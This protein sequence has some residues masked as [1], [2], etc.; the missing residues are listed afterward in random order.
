MA[1]IRAGWEDGGRVFCNVPHGQQVED[2]VV[3]IVLECRGWRQNN[4][5]VASGLVEVEINRDHE[6][7][8]VES[9][10]ELHS[11]GSRQHRVPGHRHQTADP[12]RTL[13][14]NFLGEGGYRQLAAKLGKPAHPAFSPP[15][16]AAAGAGQQIHRRFGEHCSTG[17]VEISGDNV[18]H[19]DEPLAETTKSLGGHTHSAVAHGRRSRRKVARYATNLVACD[20]RGSSDAFGRK[21]PSQPPNG[22]QR[23][24]DLG[25]A[26]GRLE[27]LSEDHMQE[28]HQQQ[29]VASRTDEVVAIGDSCRL[30]A[31]RVDHHQPAAAMSEL[32]E[33][34]AKPRRRHHAAVGHNRVGAEHEQIRGAVDIGHRQEQLVPEHQGRSDV[35][36]KLIDR[37]RRETVDRTEATQQRRAVEQRPPIVDIWVAEVDTD[38]IATVIVLDSPNPLRGLVEGRIPTDALPIARRGAPHRVTQSIRVILDVLQRH[39]LGAN[40][41]ATEAVLTI[42]ADRDD[43]AILDPDFDAA[44]GLAQVAG[45]VMAISPRSH[46][47]FSCENCTGTRGPLQ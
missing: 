11:V 12:A 14:Q 15:E 4:V 13:G 37:G 6:V 36:R 26:A 24:A 19:V 17:A 35:V 47:G 38:R 43:T 28:G 1:G 30:G 3:V 5:A 16:L 23:V 32:F 2:Q 7:E 44:D 29:G 8:V 41:T 46:D 21:I 34:L 20:P 10:F 27:S 18:E 39:R 40:V 42:T 9:S 31:P 22:L 45:P 33:T 25:Q